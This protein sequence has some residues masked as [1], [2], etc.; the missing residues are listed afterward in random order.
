MRMQLDICDLGDAMRET[1]QWAP[2]G[3]TF[4][5]VCAWGQWY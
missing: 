5:N 4:D 2:V 3:Y 1:K